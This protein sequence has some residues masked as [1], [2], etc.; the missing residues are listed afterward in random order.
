MVDAI[1]NTDKGMIPI[2]A[3]FPMENFMKMV[4]SETESEKDSFLHDF[5]KLAWFANRA[6]VVKVFAC[7][8]H[9]VP[10]FL[11]QCRYFLILCDLDGQVLAPFVEV[12]QPAG[13]S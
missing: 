4:A 12:H 7:G 1:L 2:D 3:K 9:D 8:I 13:F 6:V 10:V 5:G 11:G